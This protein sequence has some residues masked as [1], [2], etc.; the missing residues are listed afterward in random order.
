MFPSFR[1]I[2]LLLCN[3]VGSYTTGEKLQQNKEQCTDLQGR[4]LSWYLG[5]PHE[6]VGGMEEMDGM[7]REKPRVE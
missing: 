1:C 2:L 5:E 7:G 3:S 4:A 6:A